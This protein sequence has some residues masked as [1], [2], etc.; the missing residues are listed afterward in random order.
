MSEI[1]EVISVSSDDGTDEE[2]PSQG[3]NANQENENVVEVQEEA[4]QE[5]FQEAKVAIKRRRTDDDEDLE[6]EEEQDTEPLN[7]CIIAFA[8]PADIRPVFAQNL[9]AV[10]D[11]T[12][13]AAYT[14][15]DIAITQQK[16]LEKENDTLK[17]KIRDLERIIS[18]SIVPDHQKLKVK[19]TVLLN[20]GTVRVGA[21]SWDHTGILYVAHA[22]GSCEFGVTAWDIEA[23]SRVFTPLHSGVIRDVKIRCRNGVRD[24]VL[25]TGLDKKLKLYSSETGYANMSIELSASGWSCAF[26][27]VRDNIV[28]VGLGNNSIVQLYDI[29]NPSAVLHSLAHP[30][31]GKLGNGVHS[32]HH[33]ESSNSIVGGSLAAS[34]YLEKSINKGTC[35]SVAEDG[36]TC[37]PLA[38]GGDKCTNTFYNDATSTLFSTW[39]RPTHLTHVIE[40]LEKQPSEALEESTTI[41]T[42]TTTFNHVAEFN[43]PLN[44]IL[45]RSRCFNLRNG[46]QVFATGSD[47]EQCAL[48]Q[49][50]NGEGV[51]REVQRLGG[52]EYEGK[53]MD[54][55]PVKG[56]VA[57]VTDSKVHV[58]Q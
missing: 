47:S 32:L 20:K 55:V 44:P 51:M 40:T 18:T 22:M 12:L 5:V 41:P 30:S 46:T 52:V 37:I 31:M 38:K 15:R 3:E 7:E 56:Y 48:L 25:S 53:V 19:G 39:R 54:I 2:D 43:A 10:D 27:T 21:A 58:W 4:T 42:K 16:N 57:V 28:Y 49:S 33:I 34:F 50:V 24:V 23:K 1:A 36:F 14:A 45:T 35:F 6:R 9:T 8:K 13:R 26:D 11:S 29:R 17:L